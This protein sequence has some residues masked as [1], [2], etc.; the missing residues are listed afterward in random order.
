VVPQTVKSISNSRYLSLRFAYTN[1]HRFSHRFSLKGLFTKLILGYPKV[2]KGDAANELFQ[3]NHYISKSKEEYLRKLKI[4][5]VGFMTGE[6]TEEN[7]IRLNMQFNQVE[8]TNILRF[9]T[10]LSNNMYQNN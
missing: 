8:N 9:L 5:K 2:I 3:L 7:F 6:E 1:V 4:N 10:K